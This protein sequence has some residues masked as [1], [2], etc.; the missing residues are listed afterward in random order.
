M[1]KTGERKKTDTTSSATLFGMA[2]FCTSLIFPQNNN[3]EPVKN[4]PAILRPY[5]A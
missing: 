3:Q 1:T 2:L 4:H 5:K